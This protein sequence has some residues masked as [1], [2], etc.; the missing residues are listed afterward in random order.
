MGK[1]AAVT[2]GLGVSLKFI[3]WGMT[4]VGVP[5]GPAVI[6]AGYSLMAAAGAIQAVEK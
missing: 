6:G 4:C 1:V 3:G 5:A 2:F